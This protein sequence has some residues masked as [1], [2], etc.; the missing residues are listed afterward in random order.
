MDSYAGLDLAINTFNHPDQLVDFDDKTTF[1]L[2][3][4]ISNLAIKYTRKDSRQMAVFNL[5]TQDHNFEMILF[6]DPYEKNASRMEEGKLALIHGLIGRRNGEMSLAAHEVFD[7]ANSIPK[8]I[9]RIQF[10]LHNTRQAADFIQQLRSMIDESYG[11]TRV[12]ISFLVEGQ[13]VESQTA[14]SLTF[15]ISNQN[16]KSLRRHP[17]LAGVRIQSI[18]VKTIDDRP[19]WQKR[20]KA[21]Y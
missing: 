1:R 13:I 10:I 9:T 4:I 16:Y 19:A 5:S 11:A 15:T 17:A 18:P 12:N 6:P 3:G 14:Q 2:C 20:K 8:I 21:R 7:L